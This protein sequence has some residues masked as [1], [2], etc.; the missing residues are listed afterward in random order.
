VA[1]LTPSRRNL[2]TILR[3]ILQLM[4]FYLQDTPHYAHLLRC[5]RPTVFPQILGSFARMFKL[6]RGEMLRRFWAQGS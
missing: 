1:R 3:L 5:F 4:R 6:A 2:R